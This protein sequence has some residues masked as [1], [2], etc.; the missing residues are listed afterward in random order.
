MLVLVCRL[1]QVCRLVLPCRLVD[2]MQVWVCRQV[3][4]DR[5]VLACRQE[6]CGRLEQG[7][8]LELGGRRE[9]VVDDYHS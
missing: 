6:W 7:Y 8:K 2:G 5:L 9:Y 1:G 3:Q 4:G